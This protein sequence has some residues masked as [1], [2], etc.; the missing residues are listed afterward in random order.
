[1]SEEKRIVEYRLVGPVSRNECQN[2]E[3]QS[4]QDKILAKQTRINELI[5]KLRRCLSV[6]ET[7]QVPNKL[8]KQ[9]AKDMLTRIKDKMGDIA[10]G[11]A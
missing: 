3:C 11:D 9:L 4:L 2:D 7:Y 10:G 5:W 1:M 6:V 8:D